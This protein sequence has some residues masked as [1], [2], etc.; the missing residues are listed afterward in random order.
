MAGTYVVLGLVGNRSLLDWAN[1]GR[2]PPPHFA[3]LVRGGDPMADE[4][5]KSKYK[6]EQWPDPEIYQNEGF[7]G[8]LHRASWR[9]EQGE[10]NARAAAALKHSCRSI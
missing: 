7:C 5:H 4:Y 8:M 6:K 10:G 1:G 9:R 3:R 2:Q